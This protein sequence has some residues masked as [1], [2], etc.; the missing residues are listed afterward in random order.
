MIVDMNGAAPSSTS[1]L[2][3]AHRDAV[4]A[5]AR[6]YGAH[7][8]RVFGSVARAESTDESDIDLLVDVEPRTS[9]LEVVAL[10]QNLE[11]LLGRKVDLLT[12]E[13]LSPYLR[14]AILREAVPL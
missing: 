5:L 10:W 4:I 14:D 3:M 13:G 6:R 1:A 2:L 9:L 12:E 11:E 7:N 8:V